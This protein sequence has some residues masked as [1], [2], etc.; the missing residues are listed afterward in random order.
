MNHAL[1]MAERANRIFDTWN[2]DDR[3]Q[4]SFEPYQAVRVD[5]PAAQRFDDM[6][7]LLA[8]L[9]T[10]TVSQGWI[11]QPSSVI[12]ITKAGQTLPA[13]APWLAAELA[14]DDCRSSI[15]VRHDGHAFVC[16]GVTELDDDA[17]Q[18]EPALVCASSQRLTDAPVAPRGYTAL[19]YRVI[20]THNA[21]QGWHPVAARFVGFTPSRET[22]A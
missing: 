15:S 5:M 11:M 21:Q 8:W 18:G 1:D 12:H 17:Q 14:L 10:Q 7:A 13:D 9:Q 6:P 4:A 16:A 3:H 2:G 19:H 20:H 22:Q